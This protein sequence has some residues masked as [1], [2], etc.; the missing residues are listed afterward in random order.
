MRVPFFCYYFQK[1]IYLE[2]RYRRLMYRDCPHGFPMGATQQ[3]AVGG[4]ERRLAAAKLN[5]IPACGDAHRVS[6]ATW[7]PGI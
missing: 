7:G 4:D 3:V 5:N 2:N 1:K 6:A